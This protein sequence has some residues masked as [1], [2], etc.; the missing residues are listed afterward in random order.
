[1]LDPSLTELSAFTRALHWSLFWAKSIQF[2]PSHPTSQRSILILSTHLRLGLPSGLFPSGIPTNILYAFLWMLEG[3]LNVFVV[4]VTRW[5]EL[6]MFLAARKLSWV[7]EWASSCWC[8]IQWRSVSFRY[9]I[10]PILEREMFGP[11][12]GFPNWRNCLSIFMERLKKVPKKCWSLAIVFKWASPKIAEHK[13]QCSVWSDL[14]KPLY[15]YL[16]LVYLT[17][18]SPARMLNS[19]M[20]SQ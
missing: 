8:F 4:T 20:I 6:A 10:G 17:V 13:S 12:Y 2:I 9:Y 19:R 3:L 15:K 5:A 14:F 16:S 7:S 1:M 11:L 18:L